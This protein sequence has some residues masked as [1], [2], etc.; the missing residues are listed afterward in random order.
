MDNEGSKWDMDVVRDICNT[1]DTKLIMRIPI[2]VHTRA[3]SWFWY[4]EDK[5]LFT[6]KSCYKW[7]QGEL[8]NDMVDLWRRLWSLKIPGKVS[9]LLWRICKGC[10]PTVQALDFKQVSVDNRCPWCQGA[11]ETDTTMYSS[12]TRRYNIYGSS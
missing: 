2:P 12:P 8:N 1:R 4:L 7:L 11:S 3:D 10:L 9:N 5:G 6:V